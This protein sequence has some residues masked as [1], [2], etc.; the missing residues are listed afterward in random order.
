[1]L[2]LNARRFTPVNAGLIPTGELAIVAG[3]PFD[4][5]TPH[6][7]GDRVDAPHEQLKFSGGYDHNWVLDGQDGKL[8]LAAKVS[9]PTTGRVLEVLTTEPG[10]QFYIGNFLP[11]LEDPA[12]KQN[13]GKSGKP[14]HFRNAF[15]LETQHYPDSINHPTFPS[16]V[17]KPGK[18]YQSVTVFKFSAK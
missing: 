1:M 10:I 7:I 2:Q 18:P 5:T 15:C 9:E 6:R 16:S 17:V 13:L 11:K 4:F 14:Y 12:D 3:T 8:A